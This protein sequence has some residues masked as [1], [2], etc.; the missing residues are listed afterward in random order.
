VNPD[1]PMIPSVCTYC[2][3]QQSHIASCRFGPRANRDSR[4]QERNVQG[5]NQ[6]QFRQPQT[7]AQRQRQSQQ[8]NVRF[9]SP[10]QRGRSQSPVRKQCFI[11]KTQ[12]DHNGWDCPTLNQ[13]SP[14]TGDTGNE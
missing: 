13:E 11:C 6:N 10:E 2:G 9:S 7:Y 12:D 3:G 1:E 4:P 8:R 14:P 5:T